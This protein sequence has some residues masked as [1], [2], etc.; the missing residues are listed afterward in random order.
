[1]VGNI[2]KKN[3]N[4]SAVLHLIPLLSKVGEVKGGAI[5]GHEEIMSLLSATPSPAS[6]TG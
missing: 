1:M 4:T 3:K 6:P 2:S 5:T